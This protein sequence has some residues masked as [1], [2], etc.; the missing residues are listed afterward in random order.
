[1]PTNNFAY[2]AYAL[3]ECYKFANANNEFAHAKANFLA[4][5]NAKK[6]FAHAKMILPMHK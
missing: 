2:H 3:I 6:E 5:P 4:H 1:M